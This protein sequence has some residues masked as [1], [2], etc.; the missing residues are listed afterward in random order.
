MDTFD[1]R[2]QDWLQQFIK[3]AVQNMIH[4]AK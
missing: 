4:R 3:T 1:N 2:Q